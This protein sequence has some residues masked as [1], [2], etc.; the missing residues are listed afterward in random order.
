VNEAVPTPLGKE[1]YIVK[2]IENC[3]IN[4][5]LISYDET[6]DRYLFKSAGDK[7]WI[8]GLNFP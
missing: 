3:Y 5:N 8:T 6:K 2:V 1:A 4:I 7:I